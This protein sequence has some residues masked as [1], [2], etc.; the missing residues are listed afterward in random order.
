MTPR[1][2]SAPSGFSRLDIARAVAV[3]VVLVLFLGVGLERR[4][5]GIAYPEPV[6]VDSDTEPIA[7]EAGVFRTRETEL[8]V[9]PG[10]A[11]KPQAHARS[12]EIYRRLRAYP[13]APPRISHGL[14]EEEF[15]ETSCNAC[16][17]RGGW[18]ARFGT[19]APVTPHPGYTA[20]LQC[21]VP[22]DELVG[23]A[24]PASEDAL[25]CDQ[26][27]IDP[28]APLAT[29]VEID[30]RPAEWPETDRQAMEGSPHVIP[31]GV[32]S[33]SNCLACHA[34]PATVVGLRTDH[35]ERGNCRQCHVPAG[36]ADA[37]WPPVG[38]A[39]TMDAAD[40]GDRGSAQDGGRS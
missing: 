21:H 37:V 28:D 38:E 5:D 35:P 33:R 24:R 27:H 32:E 4:D 2:P 16:H 26:C 36:D 8:A 9:A 3:M 29:F 18:V 6:S 1:R 13:G 23:R 11:G 17:R 19:Y 34:G 15:H 31:H 20:C 7:S 39:G 22:L 12:P 30:W 40:S 14:T 10:F 25:V